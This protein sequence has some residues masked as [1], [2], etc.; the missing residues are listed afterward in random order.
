[1]S[2]IV[3]IKTEVQD[4]AAVNAACRR[5]HFPLP[6]RDTC[7]LYKGEAKADRNAQFQQGGAG[8]PRQGDLPVGDDRCTAAERSLVRRRMY[9]E[10][11]LAGGE[12]GF[13]QQFDHKLLVVDCGQLV[14]AGPCSERLLCGMLV[15]QAAPWQRFRR[16]QVLQQ[17]GQIRL[18]RSVGL[19]SWNPPFTTIRNATK[20]NGPKGR[21]IVWRVVCNV[22]TN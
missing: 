10:K 20:Q 17:C 7:K 5:L 15:G 14:D 2:H 11:L 1:M 4:A 13:G 19:P 8:F 18:R 12:L 22:T 9:R 6:V 21:N 3:Q 16:L